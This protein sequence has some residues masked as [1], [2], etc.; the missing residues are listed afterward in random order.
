MMGR[1]AFKKDDP[2]KYAYHYEFHVPI[3]VLTTH[4]P[5][6]L[7]KQPK[8]LNLTFGQEGIENPISLAKTAAS[9]R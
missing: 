6:K 4:I 9:G 3:F 1:Y 8:L 5:Q 7:F 2:E